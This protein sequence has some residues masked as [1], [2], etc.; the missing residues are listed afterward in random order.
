[1][2]VGHAFP[3]LFGFWW[4]IWRELAPPLFADVIVPSLYLPGELGDGGGLV[5][6][7]SVQLADVVAVFGRVVV[8]GSSFAAFPTPELQDGE[9]SSK[10]TDHPVLKAEQPEDSQ[11]QGTVETI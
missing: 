1:M 5:S 6:I 2:G 8:Q 7:P 3:T 4:H 11:H 10:L 9:D